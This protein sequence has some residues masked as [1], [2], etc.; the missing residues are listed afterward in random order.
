MR[1]NS[2]NVANIMGVFNIFYQ[3]CTVLSGSV[4]T[5]TWRVVDTLLGRGRIPPSSAIDVEAFSQFFAEKVSKV[6]SSTS[7]APQAAFSHVQPGVSFQHFSQLA[8]N[9]RRHYGNTTS[10]R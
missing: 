3:S 4:S 8:D 6:R 2:K 1:D 9:R 5:E 10:A 7:D